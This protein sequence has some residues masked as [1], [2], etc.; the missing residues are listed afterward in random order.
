MKKLVLKNDIYTGSQGKKSLIDLEIP[1]NCNGKLI[2]FLHGYMGYKD[3]GAWNLMQSFFTDNK[4]AFCKFNFS[5]N[6]GT[7]KNPIDF[8]DLDAFSKNTYSIEKNDVKLVLDFLEGKIEIP[9]EIILI[10]HSRGGGIALLNADDPRISKIVTLAAISSIEK[11]FAD[12]NILANWKNEG[13][14]FLKNQRTMQEMPHLYSQVEDFQINKE[15][16]NIEHACKRNSKPILIIHGEN[17]TSVPISEGE[18]I[19]IWCNEKV[20]LLK[21]TDHVFGA[22]QP[23]EETHLPQK[24][25]EVCEIILNFI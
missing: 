21:E 19:A 2:L 13:V 10:G 18:E 25:K 4:F 8:P 20:N 15:L 17:D 23:W 12:S 16:L 7:I 1:E 24:L 22:K 9:Q 11:R 5:H 14:R 6:G 3:W